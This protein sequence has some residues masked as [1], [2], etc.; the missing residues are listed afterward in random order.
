[1]KTKIYDDQH[2]QYIYIYHSQHDYRI[3]IILHIH[4][5]IYMIQ[6]RLIHYI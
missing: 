4:A 5:Y 3:G 2:H 6:Y 1:M